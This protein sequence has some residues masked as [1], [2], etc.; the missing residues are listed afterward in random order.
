M[1]ANTSINAM[2]TKT[3][4]YHHSP[5]QQHAAY[6]PDTRHVDARKVVQQDVAYYGFTLIELLAVLAIVGVLISLLLPAVQAAREAARRIQCTN[7]L[8]Q[9]GL[10]ALNYES[11]H[12]NLPPAA[13]LDPFEMDFGSITYPVVDH[14]LGKQFSWAVLL[15]PYLEQQNLQ[16]QFDLKKSVFE[17][18]GQPQSQFVTSYLCP[19]D[20]AN[21]R[22]F[23]DAELTHG[24]A[25][26]KG[27]YAAYVSPFHI[28]LQLIY[29]GALIVTGQPLKQIEDGVSRTLAFSEVR[30][31]D[32]TQD[33]RGVWSLPWAGASLLSFDMHHLC[34]SG[35]SLCPED[36]YFRG[37]PKSLGQTQSPNS[38][39]PTLDTLRLCPDSV[40]LQAQLEGMPC[41]KW[42]F[43]IGIA[44]F[45]SA[46]PRSLHPGGV[47]VTYVDGHTGFVTDEVDEFSMAYRV[48]VND[49]Q[50]DTYRD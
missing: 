13:V 6:L 22:L 23:M 34:A 42:N 45:Y 11:A 36:R 14:R 17:Q 2:N 19:S 4:I 20:Q 27:N 21:G 46:S 43:P 35:R 1:A 44:G 3:S 25:F 37:N 15:L 39:G 33:E 9:I 41:R 16:A 10:A 48:S 32:T 5:L 26:A 12:G 18:A 8:R 38:Q 31:L 24:R 50:S 47:N 30:T 28:D 29:P 40:Q 49:G 7:H